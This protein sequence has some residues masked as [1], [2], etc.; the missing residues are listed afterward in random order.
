MAIVSMN[1][2]GYEDSATSGCCRSA[3]TPIAPI[4]SVKGGIA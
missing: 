4:T 1:S 3:S 2:E